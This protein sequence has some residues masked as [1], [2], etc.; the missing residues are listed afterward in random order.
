MTMTVFFFSNSVS[1]TNNGKNKPLPDVRCLVSFTSSWCVLKPCLPKSL[2]SQNP[3]H[4][5]SEAK[6]PSIHSMVYILMD[7]SLRLPS[8]AGLNFRSLMDT[9]CSGETEAPHRISVG[10]FW[11]RTKCSRFL[12]RDIALVAIIS[13][14]EWQMLV[15]NWEGERERKKTKNTRLMKSHK[16][17][18]KLQDLSKLSTE[19]GYLTW[20][21]AK[22]PLIIEWLLYTIQRK[23]IRLLLML[24]VLTGYITTTTVTGASQ[25]IRISWKIIV[26]FP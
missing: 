4:L 14:S 8:E 25:K 21:K 12:C 18:I 9:W 13:R 5:W 1:R 23:S 2:R 26:F 6:I 11:I 10:V 3:S 19:I 24:I 20:S 22:F 17:T 16:V 15:M 7:F